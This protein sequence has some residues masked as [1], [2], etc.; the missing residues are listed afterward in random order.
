MKT[1]VFENRVL[2]RIFGH[3]RDE[4]TEEWTRLHNK[5]LYTLHFSPN[6]IC[7]IKSR[8]LRWEGQVAR[9]GESRGAYG[10]LVWELEGRSKNNENS[11]NYSS[12]ITSVIELARFVINIHSK[13]IPPV[14]Q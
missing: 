10:V 12:R 13:K 11:A 5:E 9:M 8:K 2:R 3:K 4:V 1:L 14:V 6:I 7:V